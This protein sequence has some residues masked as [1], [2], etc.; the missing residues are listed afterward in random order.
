[1]TSRCAS[2]GAERFRHP[3]RAAGMGGV[4]R[5]SA[6]SAKV[7]RVPERAISRR[8][9][10]LG[11]LPLAAGLAIRLGQVIPGGKKKQ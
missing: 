8:S 3:V 2:R 4:R 6:A 5:V 1:M 10:R 9:S 11:F 7:L